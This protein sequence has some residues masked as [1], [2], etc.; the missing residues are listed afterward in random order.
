MSTTAA[1]TASTHTH[2]TGASGSGLW[3]HVFALLYN[4]LL[5]LGE[6]RGMAARR[7]ELL[8]TA[9]GRTLEIGAGTGHN[10]AAYPDDLDALVLT[11]PEPGMLRK[12]Q[13]RVAR[14]P[15]RT[16]AR[17]VPAGASALP[18][19]DD[20]FDTLVSTM[21]LC[22]V[23]D[24]GAAIDELHRVLRPGGRLLFIE[25]VRSEDPRLARRQDRLERPWRAFGAG[26]R[27]NRPT[28]ALLDER[29]ERT[30]T[31]TAVW[32]GM[33][34]IIHPLVVGEAIA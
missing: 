7:R 32:R 12:L 24:P 13:R 17:T 31:R 6:R 21:V 10:L 22:T 23:D 9:T 8:A 15:V 14:S 33:P 26:C 18:F 27:C 29:F 11:E 4:P 20:S 1:T 5:A 34:S 28:L 30:A 3:G 25:H 19:P 16:L 2:S